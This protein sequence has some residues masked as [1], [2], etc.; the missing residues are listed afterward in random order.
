VHGLTSRFTPDEE[1]R[2][3]SLRN[4]HSQLI[5]RAAVGVWRAP[6]FYTSISTLPS[7]HPVGAGGGEDDLE[8]ESRDEMEEDDA[9]G[10]T[11]QM[12]RRGRRRRRSEDGAA[13][14]EGT[15]PPHPGGKSDPAGKAFQEA[16]GM[17][18]AFVR[19]TWGARGRK[20]H[21][22]GTSS[23]QNRSRGGVA[24]WKG[25]RRPLLDPCSRIHQKGDRKAMPWGSSF[26]PERDLPRLH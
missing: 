8:M 11:E 22:R 14:G 9:R 20:G 19:R 10:W 13:N 25:P 4:K 6:R 24:D 7:K 16:L 3:E 26:R 15:P 23:R 17:L 2:L 5:K 18:V 1:L 21:R 12:S